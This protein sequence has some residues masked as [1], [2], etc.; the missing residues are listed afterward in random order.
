MRPFL[1]WAGGKRW[2]S[3]NPKI[4]IPS[5]KRYVE[6]FLGGGAMFFANL[7]SAAL[8]SDVNPYLV[9]CFI[10]MRDSAEEVRS[11]LYDHFAQHSKSYYYHVRSG[12]GSDGLANAAAFIYLNRACFNGLF[13]VNLAG[14]FNVPIGTK[15]FKLDDDDEFE[16][17]SKALKSA[18]IKLGDFES[19]I[20]A[21]KSGDF[22]FVDPPYTVNHNSNG[23]VEY[24]ENIFSWN[25]QV[26]L[27]ESLLRAS[28]RGVEF[29]L[30][31]A[32][33]HSV[34][35]LYQDSFPMEC[36][37]RGSEMASKTSYRGRTTE[38]LVFSH[39]DVVSSH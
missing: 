9:N 24:N 23:F 35:E 39:R 27:S 2:L 25:D 19:L 37:E 1:R 31:N 8:L 38:L 13:R 22:L 10:H 15:L 18:E 7:P 5:D 16:R 14:Q 3:S 17:W 32:D 29:I 11:S 30:T 28:K 20:D 21:C 12:L 33:H 34:R 26:R 6:P 36:V 4:H